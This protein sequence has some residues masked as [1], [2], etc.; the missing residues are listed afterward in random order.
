MWVDYIER[1]YCENNGKNMADIQSVQSGDT[2]G[3]RP[4]K[5]AYKYRCRHPDCKHPL[6]TSQHVF[7]RHLKTKHYPNTAFFCP[8][9]DCPNNQNNKKKYPREDN[10]REHFVSVHKRT[11]DEFRALITSCT[12]EWECP[13][14]C[15]LCLR[16][17]V[18]W[19]DFYACFVKH[20]KLSDDD[21]GSLPGLLPGKPDDDGTGSGSNDGLDHSGPKKSANSKQRS[22]NQGNNFKSQS[23]DQSSSQHRR[24]KKRPKP[25]SNDSEPSK[26]PQF[27]G[28]PPG[29][30]PPLVCPS[31][32]RAPQPQLQPRALPSR[33]AH[34]HP[35]HYGPFSSP[36]ARYGQRGSVIMTARCNKC[37]HAFLN[38]HL[39]SF[40]TEP[41]DECH[42]C[43]G[44][45][46]DMAATGQFPTPMTRSSSTKGGPD[47]AVGYNLSTS[48]HGYHMQFMD[49]AGQ[50]W[51]PQSSPR[52]QPGPPSDIGS[53]RES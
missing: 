14:V 6:F 50:A 5:L 7:I 41:T 43:V 18:G 10:C 9:N 30:P 48:S 51:I 29:D 15:A 24:P 22:K 33:S 39:C 36:N 17:V 46:V 37:G 2:G 1:Y 11:V 32:P 27:L 34:Y 12:T 38:C 21:P 4:D 25:S 31:Q 26:A 19:G 52:R 3:K 44:T 47:G 35:S 53:E 45:F 28:S 8:E 42:D 23:H 16:E 40:R 49:P 20:C 13:H